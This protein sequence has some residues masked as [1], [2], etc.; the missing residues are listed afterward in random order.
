[1]K[2]QCKMYRGLYTRD[3]LNHSFTY[4]CVC[5]YICNISRSFKDHKITN[6]IMINFTIFDSKCYGVTLITK[7][8]IYTF[9]STINLHNS[10]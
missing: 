6:H 10:N 4:I 8:F 9:V 2:L 1:M 5:L 7:K 3:L